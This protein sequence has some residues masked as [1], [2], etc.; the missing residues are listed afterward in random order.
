MFV[1]FEREKTVSCF[2][3]PASNMAP[4]PAPPAANVGTKIALRLPNL[5][6]YMREIEREIG[7]HFLSAAYG[8]MRCFF[9]RV[10]VAI[11]F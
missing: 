5:R 4:I 8:R 2:R 9:Q 7:N 6:F 3:V 1:D 11:Q 10:A